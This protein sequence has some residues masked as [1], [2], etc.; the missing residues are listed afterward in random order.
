[1]AALLTI[2]VAIKALEGL[3]VLGIAIALALAWITGGSSLV[4]VPFLNT[5][6]QTMRSSYDAVKPPV[7]EAL[8]VLHKTADIVKDI[9]PGTTEAMV[10]AEAGAHDVPSARGLSWLPRNELP[11]QD[12]GFDTLCGKAGS[13]AADVVTAPL[14]ALPG[15][16]GCS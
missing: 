5:M 8:E 13:Y 4:A 12:D 16:G 3:A 6:R 11:V 10:L 2:L 15:V 9:V 1:M 7:F 14:N